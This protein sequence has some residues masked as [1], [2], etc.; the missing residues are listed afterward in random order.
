MIEARSQNNMPME[1]MVN[2]TM[3]TPT[4]SKSVPVTLLNTN[5]YNVWIQQ[6]LLAA[7]IVE[8]EHCPWDFH[9]IM[10]RGGDQVQVS[11]CPVPMP[12]VQEEIFSFGV[13]E[14]ESSLNS[15]E[16]SMSTKKGTR[17]KASIWAMHPKFDSSNFDFK[18]ELE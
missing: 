12:E 14:T 7:N 18:K 13:T 4:K 5:Y 10:S 17:G 6:S 8:V 1:V 11:F 2:R 16:L 3:V 9:S 15:G